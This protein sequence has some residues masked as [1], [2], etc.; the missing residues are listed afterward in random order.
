MLLLLISE[1]ALALVTILHYSCL[2]HTSPWH[3]EMELHHRHRT[4]QIL[5]LL[6]ELSWYMSN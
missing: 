3:Q 6:T 2:H 4:V 1:N 5:A